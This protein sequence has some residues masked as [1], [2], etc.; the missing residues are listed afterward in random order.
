MR[1]MNRLRQ[2]GRWLSRYR[3]APRALILMY[4]RVTD[5]RNDPHLL[6]VTPQ[7]FAEH[8]EVIRRQYFPIRLQH[9]VDALR[10]GRVPNRAVAITFDDGYADNLYCAKPILERYEVPATVFVTAGQVGLDRE[11]WW[12]ELDRL[13]LQPGTLP[14]RLLVLNGIVSECELRES[15]RYTE[16]DYDRHRSWHLEWKEDPSQRQRLFRAI[17]KHLVTLSAEEKSTALKDLLSWSGAKPE[18][19]PSHRML[20]IDDVNLLND[21]DLLEVG[22]HTMTHPMLSSLPPTEQRNEIK[23]SKDLWRRSSTGL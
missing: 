17:F 15:A 19:R 5:L 13:L 2:A 22:A 9:L 1:G 18:S 23:H 14:S 12:D 16:A 11:C 4:H 7:H 6:S 21:G 10:H 8:M 3:L 20:T